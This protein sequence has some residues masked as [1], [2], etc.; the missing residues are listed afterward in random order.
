MATSTH[1]H[2]I[3]RKELKQP[4]E[5]LTVFDQ[6]SEFVLGNL[7][8]VVLG[9]VIVLAVVG[10][11]FAVSLYEQ[12][13]DRMASEQ[14]Y[15]AMS[16]MSEKRY[17]TA[18]QGFSQLATE[19]PNRQLGHLAQF[20]LGSAYIVQNQPAK[21]R[22]ALQAFLQNG[23]DTLFRQMALTQL[24]VADEDLGAYGNSHVAYVEAAGLEGPEKA[25]AQIGA[26][27]TLALQGDRLGAIRAYQQFLQVNPFSQQRAEVIDALA[28]MGAPPE[29][30]PVS[31]AASSSSSS[32]VT[33][34]RAA[35]I[36]S[37]TTP[38]NPPASPSANP[39]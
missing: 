24:G 31:N 18:V 7:A 3:S 26:A 15:N 2:R 25:R 12:H 35:A 33:E 6:I 27:R 9:T 29:G 8:Q 14:F 28:Q 4:D 34:Q 10:L 1:H 22:E 16:A 23:G 21:A 17:D 38:A 39:K 5:F 11:A 37:S 20:Y 30:P 13:Q 32:A 36:K 19:H